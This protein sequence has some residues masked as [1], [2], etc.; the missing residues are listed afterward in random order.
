MVAGKRGSAPGNVDGLGRKG[1]VA[2][3]PKQDD[4]GHLVL[5]HGF[6]VG[7]QGE[8]FGANWVRVGGYSTADRSSRC[9]GVVLDQAVATRDLLRRLKQVLVLS[10]QAAKASDTGGNA[11]GP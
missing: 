9:P 11:L 7:G 1:E 5:S 10:W 8:A 2:R 3:K 6:A 4:P